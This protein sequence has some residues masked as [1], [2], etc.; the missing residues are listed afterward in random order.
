[1]FLSL[2]LPTDRPSSLYQRAQRIH[3]TA[4]Q[5]AHREGTDAVMG[6]CVQGAHHSAPPHV[7]RQRG[8]W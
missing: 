6:H 7:L 4:G 5:P 3:P 1:M 8:D 2:S